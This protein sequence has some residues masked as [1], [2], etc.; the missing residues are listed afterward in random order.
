MPRRQFLSGLRAALN[1]GVGYATGKLG[2]S[3]I[4]RMNYSIVAA[5]SRRAPG[6]LKAL[7]PHLIYHCL[8]QHALFPPD[9]RFYLRFN[10]FYAERLRELDC[11][12]VFPELLE[13][14]RR[15][16]EFYQLTMPLVGY[17]DQEP[18]RA[19]PADEENCYFP[20]F[21]GKRV[22]L[23]SSFA[24][25]LRARSTRE[26]FEGVWAKTGK[27]WFEP[28]AVDALEFPYG[29]SAT[30]HARYSSSLELFDEIAAE[31]SRRDFD[32]AL[33]GAA[34]L[35]IPL[36]A[37][38]RRLGKVG[39]SLGGHLQVL[40]GVL[41]KRWRVQPEWQERYV[42]DWWID[43]PARYRPPEQGIADDGAYW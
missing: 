33:I 21:R 34:G 10:E 32:V 27:R 11:L 25:L 24:E 12:G 17:L 8:N 5:E 40:F 9:A 26:V 1:A 39:L 23:V 43:M 18:D 19:V 41:G 28:A 38:A 29:Y 7:E 35:G 31:M 2:I 13:R 3:E 6:L 37:H 14:T 16:V 36:A 22:L 30:T 4:H 42:N 20:A 15:V